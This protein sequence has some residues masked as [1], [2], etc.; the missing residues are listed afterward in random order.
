MVIYPMDGSIQLLNNLGQV[1]SLPFP[2]DHYHISTQ[3][4]LQGILAMNCLLIL[5]LFA[6]LP[7]DNETSLKTF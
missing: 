6:F 2:L 5:C 4:T 3:M 7:T 1:F